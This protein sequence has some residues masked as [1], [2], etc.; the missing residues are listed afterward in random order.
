MKRRLCSSLGQRNP[1]RFLGP[2]ACKL[3][4]KGS[5]LEAES[6]YRHHDNPNFLKKGI[7]KTILSIPHFQNQDTSLLGEPKDPRIE[8]LDNGGIEEKPR[9]HAH[10]TAGHRN[11]VE[12]K[13]VKCKEKWMDSE[14]LATCK[15]FKI[16]RC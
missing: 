14:L 8:P 10:A 11:G 15:F 3:P 9:L 13:K 4:P 12:S 7:F 6:S 2:L 16:S 1:K 5:I